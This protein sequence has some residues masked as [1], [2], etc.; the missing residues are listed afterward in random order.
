M[1]FWGFTYRI[2]SS[3]YGRIYVVWLPVSVAAVSTEG[4]K[5]SILLVPAI[6]GDRNPAVPHLHIESVPGV[7][8]VENRRVLLPC[9]SDGFLLHEHFL[10]AL[11]DSSSE[12]LFFHRSDSA[13]LASSA[14]G[15]TV[16]FP[17]S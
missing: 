5:S 1:G 2:N 3:R 11:A 17:F 7:F 15:I 12:A 4:A 6:V 9:L 16:N 8:I 13:V 10:G 14:S